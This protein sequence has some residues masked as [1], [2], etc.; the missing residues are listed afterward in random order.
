MNNL[1]SKDKDGKILVND[2]FKICN[3]ASRCCGSSCPESC[4]I[5][6]MITRLYELEHKNDKTKRKTSEE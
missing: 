5:N 2:E 1:T 6:V 3:I 4:I